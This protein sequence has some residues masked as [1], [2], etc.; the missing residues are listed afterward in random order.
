M[1]ARLGILSAASV[2][3][4][5]AIVYFV[6]S[7][8]G[9][10]RRRLDGTAPAM[11]SPLDNLA[12]ES[13]ST[14]LDIGVW[15]PYDSAPPED[16]AD[17][18]ITTAMV[19]PPPITIAWESDGPRIDRSLDELD[20]AIAALAAI[21]ETPPES[22]DRVIPPQS[23]VSTPD[24]PRIPE[25]EPVARPWA[26]EPVPELELAR[27]PEPEPLP[28][29]EPEPAPELQPSRVVPEYTMVAPVELS[30][31]DGAQRVG[32]KAGT[33]TFLK[34]QRLAAVLLNDLKRAQ[35]D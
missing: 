28:E 25:P 12:H 6:A 21:N 20:T 11:P 3:L 29:P 18:S 27:E 30:F 4:F 26:P 17:A 9:A 1:D 19:T 10:G 23:S 7:L 14:P 8:L 33:A 34:Y 15:A 16:V 2:L 5:A 24:A 13:L 35:Q 31:A 22:E 32:I